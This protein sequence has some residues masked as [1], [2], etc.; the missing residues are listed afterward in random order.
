MAVIAKVGKIKEK[1]GEKHERCIDIRRKN[2]NSLKKQIESL[3]PQPKELC[4]IFNNNSAKDAAPNALSL[5]K[6]MNVEFEGLAPKSPEQLD[7][8]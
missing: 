7:L 8:F 4:V 6:M 5:Q 1:N 3:Q 2:F